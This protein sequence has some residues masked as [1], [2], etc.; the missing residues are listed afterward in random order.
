LLLICEAKTAATKITSK[1]Q[2]HVKQL[3]ETLIVIHKRCEPDDLPKII[4]I[5]TII[6]SVRVPYASTGQ[7]L[8]FPSHFTCV[9]CCSDSNNSLSQSSCDLLYGDRNSISDS[10]D[11]LMGNIEVTLSD[12]SDR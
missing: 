6:V 4:S 8:E 12:I 9:I 11:V 5:S 7:E 1:Q 10:D 3:L 2:Q